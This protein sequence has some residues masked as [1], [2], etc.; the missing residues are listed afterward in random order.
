MLFYVV[1]DNGIVD[2][3]CYNTT[4]PGIVYI[5]WDVW[6]KR[7]IVH[8]TFL[9]G[10]LHIVVAVVLVALLPLLLLLLLQVVVV[11]VELVDAQQ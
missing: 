5:A 3:P 1:V 6:D 8:N 9:L 7:S 2:I 10:D 11:V 4:R